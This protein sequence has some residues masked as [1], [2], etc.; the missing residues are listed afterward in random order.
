M[1]VEE[2][3]KYRLTSMEEP[4]DE[5]LEYIMAEAAAKARERGEKAEERLRESVRTMVEENKR[6]EERKS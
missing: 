5:A 6:K 1:T 3:N 4:S 2:I